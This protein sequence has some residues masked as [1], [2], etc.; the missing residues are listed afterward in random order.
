VEADKDGVVGLNLVPVLISNMQV[1][2]ATGTEYKQIADRLKDLSKEFDTVIFENNGMLRVP[3]R[4]LP[5]DYFI[6][7]I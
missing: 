5:F 6:N 3:V 1:N 2:R 7:R 4:S